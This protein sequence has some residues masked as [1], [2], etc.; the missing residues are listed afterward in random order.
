[1]ICCAR[2]K[3]ESTLLTVK[4]SRS[5]NLKTRVSHTPADDLQLPDFYL[6]IKWDSYNTSCL[7]CDT[8]FYVH[9]KY[10]MLY[11]KLM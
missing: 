11:E 5:Q 9:I 1:M 3:T 6:F 4:V 8:C 7:A 10:N 2:L